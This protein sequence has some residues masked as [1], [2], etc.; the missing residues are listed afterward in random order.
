MKEVIPILNY[1]Q[2]VEQ[3]DS[4]IF[5]F[6]RSIYKKTS[7]GLISC[8]Y[9]ALWTLWIF[10]NVLQN[11]LWMIMCSMNRTSQW[12]EFEPDVHVTRKP[13]H[14]RARFD[15]LLDAQVSLLFCFNWQ[16]EMSVVLSSLFTVLSRRRNREV[17]LATWHTCNKIFAGISTWPL[18]ILLAA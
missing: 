11:H 17:I 9:T 16:T 10:F 6:D 14:S 18:P 2:Q 7:C 5:I 8:N 12:D 3:F 13:A 15:H 4:N 1:N